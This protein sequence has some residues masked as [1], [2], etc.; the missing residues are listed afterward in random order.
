MF[1]FLRG[2][3]ERENT[4]VYSLAIVHDPES[5]PDDQDKS[6]N[7]GLFLESVEKVRKHLTSLRAFGHL[8]E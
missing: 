3:Q 6:D 4:H 5:T 8:V 7:S 1:Q 2:A